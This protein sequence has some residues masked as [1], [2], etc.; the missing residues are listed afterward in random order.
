MDGWVDFSPSIQVVLR[1]ARAAVQQQ[2][3]VIREA[4]D[5][6]E[7]TALQCVAKEESRALGG[8][9][10]KLGHLRTSL[11]SVQQGLH[12]LEGLADA[13]GDKRIQDQAFIMVGVI[14]VL[15][16]WLILKIRDSDLLNF[17]PLFS[18]WHCRNTA[19]RPICK[20]STSTNDLFYISGFIC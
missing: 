11:Q 12:I 1:E 10:E 20:C 14:V 15:D 16:C 2:Y 17:T 6:E 5:Q 9:D 3:S 7:Q 19:R 13:K 4:L 18:F 8:L